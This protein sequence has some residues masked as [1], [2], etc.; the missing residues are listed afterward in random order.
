MRHFISSPAKNRGTSVTPPLLIA[1]THNCFTVNFFFVSAI[2]QLRLVG[3]HNTSL[4]AVAHGAW[5][6]E[7]L[8]I[9]KCHF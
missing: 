9:G 2:S 4:G 6:L 7:Y 3:S 5:Q 1:M 8:K